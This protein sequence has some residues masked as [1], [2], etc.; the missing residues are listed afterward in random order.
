M[1]NHGFGIFSPHT[2]LVFMENPIVK[3]GRWSPLRFAGAIQISRS[4]PLRL[5]WGARKHCTCRRFRLRAR[6]ASLGRSHRPLMPIRLSEDARERPLQP[7][8]LRSGA[9]N[10]PLE[11]ASASLRHSNVFKRARE[12][13]VSPASPSSYT[14]PIQEAPRQSLGY[15]RNTTASFGIMFHVLSDSC[16]KTNI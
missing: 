7:A 4:R 11:T 2:F 3:I 10:W 9:L 15:P 12:Y 8:S 16:P 1:E 13:P 6:S 14:M 5:R